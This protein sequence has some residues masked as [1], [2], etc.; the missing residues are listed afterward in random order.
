MNKLIKALCDNDRKDLAEKVKAVTDDLVK[1]LT[2]EYTP[3][4]VGIEKDNTDQKLK[5][6]LIKYFKK[7]PNPND[8]NIHNLAENL[9]IDVHK[10][11]TSIYSLLSKFINLKHSDVPDSKFDPQQLKMGIKVEMKEHTDDPHIA[12]AISKA[13]LMEDKQYYSKLVKYGL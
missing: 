11:E 8:E 3:P 1:Y 9:K 4:E 7:N 10:L 13:H 6:I 2:P 5:L 12:K